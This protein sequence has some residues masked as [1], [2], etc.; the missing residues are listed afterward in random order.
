MYP[1][2]ALYHFYPLPAKSPSKGIQEKPM[3]ANANWFFSGVLC[4]DSVSYKPSAAHFFAFRAFWD[5]QLIVLIESAL[6]WFLPCEQF[7]S[8]WVF[9]CRLLFT[10]WGP[11]L[12]SLVVSTHFDTTRFP[13]LV[14]PSSWTGLPEHSLEPLLL[15]NT[16]YELLLDIHICHA[17]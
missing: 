1:V 11:L 7:L 6:S 4:D 9:A 15:A 2:K 8:P 5:W 16:C 10:S 3:S 12:C 17:I 14:L 13:V